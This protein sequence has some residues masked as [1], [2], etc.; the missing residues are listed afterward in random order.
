MSRP[1]PEGTGPKARLLIALGLIKWTNPI[2]WDPNGC[3]GRDGSL[4][5]W[6]RSD[7]FSA[8]PP[9]GDPTWTVFWEA[10]GQ[11]SYLDFDTEAA[12][13]DALADLP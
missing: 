12:A 3:G 2:V 7:M 11:L 6:E 8:D 13:L 4:W 9:D 10:P 5:V 1:I